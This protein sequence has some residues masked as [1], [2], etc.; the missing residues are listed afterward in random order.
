MYKEKIH[1]LLETHRTLNKQIDDM[2]RNHPHVEVEKLAEMKKRRLQIKDEI[3]R[4]TKL[5]WEEE[6]Q[7]TGYGDE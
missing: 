7:R 4:L 1:Q 2:E 5:Q 6:T 3:S